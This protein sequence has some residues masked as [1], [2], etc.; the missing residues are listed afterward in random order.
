MLN[1]SSTL[2]SETIDG[3]V[4]RILTR[5]TLPDARDSWGAGRQNIERRGGY[6]API[7]VVG[8]TDL[9]VGRSGDGKHRERN[10]C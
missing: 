2:T 8:S 10:D 4:E 1:I 9:S 6:V 5:A 3:A 7:Q